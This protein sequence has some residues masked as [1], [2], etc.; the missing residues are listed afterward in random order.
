MFTLGH[1]EVAAD[2]LSTWN[3]PAEVHLPLK[4]VFEDFRVL[5]RLP[6][7]TRTKVELVKL[8][9]LI[10]RTAIGSWETWEWLDLPPGELLEKLRLTSLAEIIAQTRED[11]DVLATFHAEGRRGRRTDFGTGRHARH[12]LLRFISSFVRFSRTPLGVDGHPACEACRQ[13]FACRDRQGPG[14]LPRK[15]NS[16]SAA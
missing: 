7:P 1:C 14:E 15:S 3:I 11:V 6:E 8:A 10:G 2:L 5:S 13:R 16:A 9:I 4:Y 12:F